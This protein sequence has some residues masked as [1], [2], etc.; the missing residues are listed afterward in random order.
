MFSLSVRVRE[1]LSSHYVI[2]FTTSIFSI[3]NIL[4]NRLNKENTCQNEADGQRLR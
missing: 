3:F 4:C 1:K 2:I